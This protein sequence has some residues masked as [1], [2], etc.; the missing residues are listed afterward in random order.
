VREGEIVGG[1]IGGWIDTCVIDS[2]LGDVFFR[3]IK[4]KAQKNWSFQK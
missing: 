3:G 4:K 2:W 1:G